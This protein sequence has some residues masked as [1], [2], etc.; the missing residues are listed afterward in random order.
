MSRRARAEA[1]ERADDL[2]AALMAVGRS[3]VPVLLPLGSDE[4]RATWDRLWVAAGR[5]SY[6]LEAHDGRR[7][8]LMGQ[9]EIPPPA[10][11][12]LTAIARKILDV[13]DSHAPAWWPI[14]AIVVA[15]GNLPIVQVARAAGLLVDEGLLERNAEDALRITEAGVRRLEAV[16]A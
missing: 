15:L 2:L 12:P 11:E 8:D 13:V 5:L 6:A 9:G 1:L 16:R 4:T 10:P 3:Q 7:R 14:A